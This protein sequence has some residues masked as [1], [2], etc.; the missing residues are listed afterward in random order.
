MKESLYLIKSKSMNI[1]RSY[2]FVT[3]FV[4]PLNIYFSS[5]ILFI[6]IN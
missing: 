6:L 4:I 5:M 1:S 3:Q 2:C